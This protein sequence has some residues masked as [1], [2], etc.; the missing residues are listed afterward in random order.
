MKKFFF[1]FFFFQISFNLFSSEIAIIDVDILFSSSKKG[2]LIIAELKNINDQNISIIKE[3][4][5][6][7]IDLDKEIQ[8]KKNILDEKEIKKKVDQMNIFL[9]DLESFK[10]QSNKLYQDKKNQEISNFF[11]QIEPFLNQFME[12]NSI[13][14]LIDKKNIFISNQKNDI[15]EQLLNLIDKNL[16]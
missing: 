7:I 16:K 6:I 10:I 1:I 5:K 9:K 4:E 3:K 15:T 12:N 13:N 8:S 2:K 11:K 14:F